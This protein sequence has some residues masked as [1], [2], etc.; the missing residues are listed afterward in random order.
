MVRRVLGILLILLG[1]TSIG[2][3]VASAT[4]W[5]TSDRVTA[6]TPSADV[7]LVLIEPGVAGIVNPVV[8][9]TITPAEPGQTVTLIT[10]RDTDAEGWIGD[11]AVQRVENL[12]DWTDLVTTT[13]EGTQEI[14]D[15]AVSDMWL[16]VEQVEGPL[17]LRSFRAPEDRTVLLIARDGAS[18]P[19]PTVSFT[20]KRDVATPYLMPLVGAGLAG[21][22]LGIGLFVSSF[23]GRPTRTAPADE[24]GAAPAAIDPE[25]RDT[26]TLPRVVDSDRETVILPGAAATTPADDDEGGDDEPVTL[27]RRELRAL[28]A[29]AQEAD[30]EVIAAGIAPAVDDLSSPDV[31]ESYPGW[32]R[33]QEAETPGA[34]S[35]SSR[36]ESTPGQAWRERWGVG[37]IDDDEKPAPAAAAKP[38][39]DEGEDPVDAIHETHERD[40]SDETNESDERGEEGED[41]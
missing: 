26:V 4:A 20:W 13:T 30:L 6:T 18:G 39:A 32:L 22:V 1:A 24:V 2:L 31:P 27:T 5:R 33:A 23:V 40:E 16:K 29:K 9:L 19:A 36:S 38:S 7:P 15:P 11:A 28:R 34:S 25:D 17:D 21:V 12:A 10:A 8:D 37:V 14:P 35:S 41:R 3:G